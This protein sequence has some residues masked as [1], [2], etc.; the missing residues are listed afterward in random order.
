[1]SDVETF[2]QALAEAGAQQPFAHEDGLVVTQG[3]PPEVLRAYAA[4]RLARQ[5][6]EA[7]LRQI[8]AAW[9][10][11]GSMIPDDA[12]TRWP[13]TWTFARA[14]AARCGDLERRVRGIAGGGREGMAA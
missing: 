10:G 13:M 6:A 11:A 2:A 8:V 3:V 4:A 12:P 14:W 1:M 5:P 7:I 9:A